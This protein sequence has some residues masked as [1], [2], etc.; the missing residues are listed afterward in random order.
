MAAR[1]LIL[2]NK[3]SNSFNE[4]TIFANN[5]K[6]AGKICWVTILRFSKSSA[7]NRFNFGSHKSRTRTISARIICQTIKYGLF[8][9]LIFN[10]FLTF[11]LRPQHAV[12]R[13]APQDILGV[14]HDLIC[15]AQRDKKGTRFCFCT[16][17]LR[18][19]FHEKLY[20]VSGP[21]VISQCYF[22]L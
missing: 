10:F 18:G 3:Y 5:P 17:L 14:S 7:L 4:F 19:T 11:S 21:L 1:N 8:D 15:C 20:H 12:Q 16:E 2:H 13:C 9:C 6:L 22:T